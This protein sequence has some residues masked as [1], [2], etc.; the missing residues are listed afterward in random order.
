MKINNIRR[1]QELYFELISSYQEIIFSEQVTQ[2]QIAMFIDEVQSF[3]VEKKEILAIELDNLTSDSDCFLLSGAIYLD[4]KDNEHYIFKSLG[5]KHILSDPFLKLEVF[6]RCPTIF[7]DNESIEIFRQAY[8]DIYQIL[9]EYPD[10]FYVLPIKQLAIDSELEYSDLLNKFFI[11]FI[12]SMLNEQFDEIQEF[13]DKYKSFDD[14]QSNML[15]FFRQSLTFSYNDRSLSIK[16]KCESYVN[17][18]NMMKKLMQGRTQPELF[19]ACVQSYIGQIIDILTISAVTGI[20][21]F[22]RNEQT[23][24]CLLIVMHT[25]LENEFFRTTLERTIIFYIFY[26]SFDK[27][28][29]C[30]IKFDEYI[31]IIKEHNLLKLI[32]D[33]I[34]SAK[35]DIFKSE[36]PEVAAIIEEVFNPVINKIAVAYQ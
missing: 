23:F 18:H 35:I 20:I 26:K 11:S 24:N 30:S 36:V 8:L 25:F 4:I 7:F 10:S 6:F 31:E 13:F 15:D 12:N 1:S 32:I 19:I 22:I 29:L 27:S 9:Y 3:W 21:P 14:I 2:K 17:H 28:K 33:K 34:H 5:N 16:E